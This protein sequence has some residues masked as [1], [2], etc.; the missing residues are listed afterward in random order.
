MESIEVSGK[1]V[2]EAV[3]QALMRLGKRREEVEISVLQEPSRGTFGLGSKDARVR[4]T[5]RLGSKSTRYQPISDARLCAVM[6][7]DR[8]VQCNRQEMSAGGSGH[9]RDIREG[10]R[11]ALCANGR[12]ELGDLE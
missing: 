8:G 2:D 11:R 3:Q 1:S 9:V 7:G 4:V 5:V 6:G 10:G 12:H